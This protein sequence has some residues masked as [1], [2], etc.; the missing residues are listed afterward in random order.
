MTQFTI[1]VHWYE[2][3]LLILS[4]STDMTLNA[5]N[6]CHGQDSNVWNI[7]IAILRAANNSQSL[8]TASLIGSSKLLNG[9]RLTCYLLI[10]RDEIYSIFMCI[11]TSYS[12]PSLPEK[13]CFNGKY[14]RF[15]YSPFRH[16]FL[17]RVFEILESHCQPLELKKI[18]AFNDLCNWR[19][20]EV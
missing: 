14:R 5:F 12:E 20:K 17:V 18:P 10:C 11:C 8:L 2:Q 13:R 1:N 3:S 19:L 15:K 9:D 7:F 4:V 6:Y 16:Y